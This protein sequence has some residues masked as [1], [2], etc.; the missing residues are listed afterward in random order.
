[1]CSSDLEHHAQQWSIGQAQALLELSGSLCKLCKL[2]FSRRYRAQVHTHAK[3][4]NKGLC[5]RIVLSPDAGL[6][7]NV[8]QP[9][10][11]VMTHQAG[12]YTSEQR[13]IERLAQV[14]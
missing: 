2:R 5:A 14:Q 13:D 8:T 12:D 6:I 7:L 3:Q 10:R 4:L 1:V 9:Q 11:I